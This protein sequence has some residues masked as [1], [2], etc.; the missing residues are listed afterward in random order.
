MADEK[1]IKAELIQYIEEAIRFIGDLDQGDYTSWLEG[2]RK[3][4]A[5][6]KAVSATPG[7]AVRG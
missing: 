7:K 3:V 1:A 5:E 6:A 2:A 4:L